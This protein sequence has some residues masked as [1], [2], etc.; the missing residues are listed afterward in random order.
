MLTWFCESFDSIFPCGYLLTDNH[1]TVQPCTKLEPFEIFVCGKRYDWNLVTVTEQA[2]VMAEKKFINIFF[3]LSKS[4]Y[5]Y[6]WMSITHYFW[7]RH[8][9]KNSWCISS[10]GEN[11]LKLRNF[12]KTV[13]KLCSIFDGKSWTSRTCSYVRLKTEFSQS[14]ALIPRKVLYQC[15]ES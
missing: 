4:S 15:D 12:W 11:F 10:N 1:L 13:F 8:A 6:F 14:L 7:W 9:N 5:L 2:W 3:L